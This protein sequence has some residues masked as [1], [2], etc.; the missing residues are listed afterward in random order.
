MFLDSSDNYEQLN[1]NIISLGQRFRG[2]VK[3]SVGAHFRCRPIDTKDLANKITYK[4]TKF[5][6]SQY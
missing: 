1:L 2:V 6:Q 3:C 5:G 4:N